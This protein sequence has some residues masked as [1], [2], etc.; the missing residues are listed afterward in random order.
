M[1]QGDRLGPYE[2]LGALGAGGMGEVYRAYDPRLRRDVALKVMSAKLASDP[3][4]VSRFEREAR[5]IAALSHPN[6]L[7]IYDVG[8][9][10]G[11]MFATFELLEGTTLRERL[12][13]GSLTPRK[14]ITFS[15]QIARGL[16]AA[17]ERGIIH[18]DIKPE[19]L[20]VTNDGMVKILDFGIAR[21]VNDDA[22]VATRTV[23]VATAPGE[24]LGTVEYMAPEQLRGEQPTRATD[25]FALGLV[26]YEMVAGRRAFERSSY[27]QTVAALLD[28]DP[29]PL[30]AG[31]SAGLSGIIHRLLE[32]SPTER[33]H[34][35][36][37]VAF[38]LEALATDA[39][40]SS[41]LRAHWARAVLPIVA[42]ATIAILATI[43]WVVSRR[44]PISG[45]LAL[46]TFTRITHRRGSVFRAR[47]GPQGN[48]VYAA[49]W[50]G[51]PVEIFESSE[52]RPEPRPLE[53]GSA[54]LLA[55]SH[56]GEVALAL[57]PYFPLSILQM[58]QLS[59]GSPAGGT[60]RVVADDVSAADWSPDGRELAI[61]RRVGNTYQVEWPL[62]TVIFQSVDPI[63]QL[64][65]CPKNDRLAIWHGS[66]SRMTLSTLNHAGVRRDLL[67]QQTYERGLAWTTTGDE[68][69][70]GT[71]E[72]FGAEYLRAIT[73]D[74]RIRDVVTLPGGLRLHD[75]SGNGE[76]LI[77]NGVDKLSVF[78]QHTEETPRDLSWFESS[79]VAGIAADGRSVLFMDTGASGHQGLFWRRTD[80]SA[81]VRIAEGRI[82]VESAILSSDAKLAAA[83]IDGALSVVPISHGI[84]HK[85]ST[86][87]VVAPALAWSPDTSFLVYIGMDRGLYIQRTDGSQPAR[88]LH[89]G[90]CITSVV[91]SPDG[92]HAACNASP[93]GIAITQ[94]SDGERTMLSMNQ[95][96][97]RLI[98][99]SA[100]DHVLYSYD[101]VGATAVVRRT[102]LQTGS[103]STLRSI[104]S[105][106]P[107]GVWRIHPVR[108]TP[109]GRTVAYTVSRAL[110]DL[111][112]CKGLR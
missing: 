87:V 48:V 81:P 94:L 105:Q 32:K 27:A 86:P 13:Q 90:V 80:G 60:P 55:V 69:W 62:G 54:N 85:L 16:Y 3:A 46:P 23:D 83:V 102:D 99:W 33:F 7:A 59:I 52:S 72:N 73:L 79:L 31:T 68:L 107:T 22:A 103:V 93:A 49:A 18:R 20:F 15:A 112:V 100:G 61:A 26:L 28:G 65:I 50:S 111:Y 29:P 77:S 4:R 110:A 91:I 2:I 109:D 66:V 37:D 25:L 70:V 6:I 82:L 88:L 76:V 19:N 74:G 63:S 98:G 24:V 30:P 84:P 12:R 108:I 36:H 56:S 11:V 78:V 92:S 89:K 95:E 57:N 40:S 41:K 58:G 43:S 9:E 75:I 34:S 47:F 71:V 64:R 97:G 14:A 96:A 106:D 44:A 38:A 101:L 10:G 45:S 53:F 51:Q 21:T 104:T 1:R 17:H 5:A 39:P 42:A 67:S 35:A 8:R